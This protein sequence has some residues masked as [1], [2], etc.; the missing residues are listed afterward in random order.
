MNSYKD[1]ES[2]IP[3]ANLTAYPKTLTDIPY[4]KEVFEQLNKNN[5]P[6]NW[7]VDKLA[8]EIEARVKLI[9]KLLKK[10]NITQILEL[11]AGYSTRGLSLTENNS[12]ISYVELDL[13]AV[14]DRKIDIIESFTQIPTNL[15][16]ISGNA[17]EMRDISKCKQYFDKNRKIAVINEGLLRYLTF[18]EKRSVAQ[19][20]Y[21]LLLEFG[22]VWITCD[23]TT[24]KFIVNQDTNLPDFNKNLTNVTDR[25]NANWRFKDK[26]HV[27]NF[28]GEIGFEVEFHDFIEVKNQLTSKDKLNL[29][30]GQIEKLIDG[31]IVAVMKTKQ[32]NFVKTS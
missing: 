32:E 19:N 5:F 11:A 8:P 22:G 2:I 10:Q 7:I 12:N 20:I 30:D 27:I 16:I 18:E 4:A 15:H 13:K 31:A 9:D 24:Q 23:I 1:F 26:N 29:S 17:L 6:N 3:T 25:N 28:M 14:S 21:K